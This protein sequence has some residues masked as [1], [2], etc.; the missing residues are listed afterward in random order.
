MGFSPISH[1]CPEKPVAVISCD[2]QD[3][4]VPVIPWCCPYPPSHPCPGLNSQG[5][6]LETYRI[7]T[8]SIDGLPTNS[9]PPKGHSVAFKAADKRLKASFSGWRRSVTAAAATISRGPSHAYPHGSDTA[10]SPWQRS[11]KRSLPNCGIA[12]RAETTAAS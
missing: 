6:C 5:I 2:R 10:F 3:G 7:A 1:P 9:P 11:G 12:A 8:H 4:G